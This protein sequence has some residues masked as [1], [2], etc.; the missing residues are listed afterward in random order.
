MKKGLYT[1]IITLIVIITIVSIYTSFAIGNSNETNEVSSNIED[2]ENSIIIKE[3]KSSSDTKIETN[4]ELNI[5]SGKI[6]YDD[7]FDDDILDVAEPDNKYQNQILKK[8][9]NEKPYRQR[10]KKESLIIKLKK[11]DKRWHLTPHKIK[12][13]EN[14][15]LIAKRYNISHRLIIKQN[16]IVNPDMLNP[17][18]TILIPN[19]VGVI[20]KI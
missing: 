3:I 8:K 11:K 18:N 19:K 4:D 7:T 6:I 1:K 15:W 12:T 10:Q 9:K 17:G 20:Y 14:L 16:R 13:G 2:V 5:F